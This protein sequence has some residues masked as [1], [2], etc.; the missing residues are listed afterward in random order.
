M[1]NK[2][3]NTGVE[4]ED[5]IINEFISEIEDKY[6][7]DELGPG[8]NWKVKDGMENEHRI[9]DEVKDLIDD[10]STKNAALI[11]ENEAMRDKLRL[12]DKNCELLRD[13]RD[14]LIAALKELIPIAEEYLKE[15]WVSGVPLHPSKHKHYQ[16]A[17]ERAKKLA[18]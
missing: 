15:L 11:A 9:I 4:K 18:P 12:A 10:L 8:G 17:I 13:H 7:L 16:S 3:G 1:E 14:A 5:R 2:E 6:F